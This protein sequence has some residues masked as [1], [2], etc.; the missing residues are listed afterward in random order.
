MVSIDLREE[1]LIF[2]TLAGIR[3]ETTSQV[4]KYE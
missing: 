3:G 2:D 4:V 1:P